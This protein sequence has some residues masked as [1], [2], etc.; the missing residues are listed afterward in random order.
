[1]RMGL[2]VLLLAVVGMLGVASPASADQSAP[3]T[4]YHIDATLTPGGD[5]QVTID[6]VMDFSQFRG[7]G[8]TFVFP[9]RQEDGQNPDEWFSFPISDIQVSSPSGARS[10]TS[11]ERQDGNVLLRVGQE[12]TFYTT[13]QSYIVSY[14]VK[15]LIVSNQAQSGLDEFSWNAIGGG[16]TSRMSDVQ[17]SIN[18][19][20]DVSRTACF[21][22][23]DF[24]EKCTNSA[25][26]SSATYTIATLDPGNPVQ[27]VAGFPA[28]TFGGVQQ[29]KT[30]RVTATNMFEVNAGTGATAGLLGLGAVVALVTIFRRHARDD[31]FVGLTPGLTPGKGDNVRIGKRSGKQNV[32]VAFRPPKSTRPG[33]IGT[34]VDATADTV[35]VSAT[36]VDLAVR[37]HLRI[38]DAGNNDHLLTRTRREADELVKYESKLLE[39]IFKTGDEVRVSEL[40]DASYAGLQDKAKAD[41]YARVVSRKWFKRNPATSQLAPIALGVVILAVAGVAGFGLAQIGWGLAAIPVA[42]LGIGLIVMSGRFRTRTALG[43]AVLAETKGFELYLRTAE[44]DQIKFEEGVDVFS[45]YLPYAM[46]FGVADRWAKVFADLGAAGRYEADL[47]W[48][49]GA[50]LYNSY[51]FA[52]MLGNLTHG[53]N[54]AMAEA[55]AAAAAANV[56][57]ASGSSSG[58]SGFSGGGGFGGGGGSVGS[59]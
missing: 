10:D 4:K 44:A 42:V 32:A 48:Y 54:N 37:G 13:P 5:T 25:T 52:T 36:L 34:L 17:V 49:Y 47:S 38:S 7:R 14:T 31:V 59:W 58:F 29:I 41:L 9:E 15:G 56:Q 45:R 2:A 16:T 26:G 8:P 39:R 23:T 22:G 50:N 18:G 57:G 27:V 12:D 19:P 40:K 11:L 24:Q 3:I 35:D 20:A 33:E 46:I 21:Y 28:G 51:I 6:M 1:M 55:S 53:F 43:S 30:R